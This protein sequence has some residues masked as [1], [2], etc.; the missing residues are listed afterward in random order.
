MSAVPTSELVKAQRVQAPKMAEPERQF[1][2][3]ERK[4]MDC[5]LDHDTTYAKVDDICKAVG[6]S[7]NGYYN[8]MRDGW[9]Q[10]QRRNLL[11]DMVQ[12]Q[13]SVFIKAAAETAATPG[14]DGFQDRR[15]LLNITGDHVERK[16]HNHDITA[17]VVVGVIGVSMEEL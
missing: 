14:R 8:I 2:R 7:R 16:Q 11:R 6:C 13:A 15:L 3:L 1:T 12:Q 10:E 17:R 5:L 4:I 9:F